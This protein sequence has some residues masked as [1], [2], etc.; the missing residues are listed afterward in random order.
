MDLGSIASAAGAAQ[1]LEGQWWSGQQAAEQ[2]EWAGGQSQANRDFQERMR[3]TQ[4]QTAVKDMIA[5]G[6]NPMLAYM[7]GGAGTPPGSTASGATASAPTHEV[8]IAQNAATAAQVKVLDEQATNIRADT[9]VKDASA[10]E[11]VA[12]TG[13][14]GVSIDKMKT[15]IE[16]LTELTRKFSTEREKIGAE[17]VNVRA[18]L[19]QIQSTVTL[20]RAQTQESLQRAGLSEQQAAEV[21]QRITAQLPQL[22]AELKRLQV[23]H[24]ALGVAGAQ[25]TSDVQRS[26]VGTLGAIFRI[27]NPMNQFL[28]DIHK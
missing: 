2:R 1:V 19:P 8:N 15:E 17:T 16:N 5:A 3:A 27:L 13:T 21:H 28:S 14:Y 6:L 23:T 10:A 20:L 12:R 24:S 7:Q 11:I 25:Q 22:E 4:Y 26:A 9:A 18:L